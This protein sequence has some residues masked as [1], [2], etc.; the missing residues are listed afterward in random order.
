MKY[1]KTTA[2]CPACS[3]KFL[4]AVTEEEMEED[5]VLEAMCPECGEMVELENLTPCSEATYESIVE[6]YEDSLDEDIEFD[7]DD[8]EDDFEDDSDDEW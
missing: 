1:Y 3:A 6:A 5:G 8:F 4:Y 2:R 7:V